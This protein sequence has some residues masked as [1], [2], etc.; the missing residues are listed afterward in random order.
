VRGETKEENYFRKRPTSAVTE[1]MWEETVIQKVC[2][3]CGAS[4]RVLGDDEL[5]NSDLCCNECAAYLGGVGKNPAERKR[6]SATPEERKWSRKR[7]R[8]KDAA[9]SS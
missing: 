9:V 6:S 1:H 5:F 4:I 2:L 8:I 3:I 7:T